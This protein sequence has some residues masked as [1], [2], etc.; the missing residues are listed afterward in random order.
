[1][2]DKPAHDAV[3]ADP[4]RPSARPRFCDRQFERLAGAGC[5]IRLSF[6]S[7]GDLFLPPVSPWHASLASD[8]GR[9]GGRDAVIVGNMLDMRRSPAR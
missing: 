3:D 5:G 4:F 7:I 2:V 1:M 9:L 8:A 6:D